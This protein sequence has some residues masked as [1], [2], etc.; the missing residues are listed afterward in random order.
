[1]LIL[2]LVPYLRCS[3]FYWIDRIHY[4]RKDAEIESCGIPNKF[5][6]SSPD[7]NYTINNP[8]FNS[9]DNFIKFVVADSIKNFI[10]FAEIFV[11]ILM[12]ILSKKF[13]C[14]N[15]IFLFFLE[16]KL[17]LI[18]WL[19]FNDIIPF[20]YL[21]K[22]LKYSRFGDY[23]NNFLRI[24][25]LFMIFTFLYYKRKKIRSEKFLIVINDF[26][27][28]I[29]FPPFFKY[30]QEQLEK[31]HENALKYLDFWISFNILD[32]KVFR[33]KKLLD[34]IGKESNNISD[35]IKLQMNLNNN[36]INNLKENLLVSSK[37]PNIS[38]N[39]NNNNNLITMNNSNR[40]INHSENQIVSKL[41]KEIKGKILLM[42]KKYFNSSG[43]NSCSFS[44]MSTKSQF[45]I[46]FPVDMQ[47]KVEEIIANYDQETNVEEIFEESYNFVCH[48]LSNF[49]ADLII[50]DREKLISMLY[51]INFFD[52]NEDEEN[53]QIEII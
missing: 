6:N 4:L 3:L 8:E 40:N 37:N 36:H 11:Y 35:A 13:P 1:M 20:V 5:I 42:Y 7:E 29:N 9:K 49:H 44:E 22:I 23:L 17:V 28:F 10:N 25:F 24:F 27:N 43:Y 31:S 46:E 2:F 50:K 19:F 47:E 32:S 33:R 18:V 15:D 45:K 38:N 52:L 41:D 26:N 34:N 16:N 51:V 14:K 21:V 12:F 53:E 39:N 48:Y 30:I